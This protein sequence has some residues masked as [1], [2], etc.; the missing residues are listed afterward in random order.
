MICWALGTCLGLGLAA[1]Q[2]LPLGFLSGQELG[3][4]RPPERTAAVVDDRSAPVARRGVH[5]GALCLWEP[6]PG[7]SQSGASPGRP[8]PE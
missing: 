8:Q 7:S 4:E 1:V 3:L 6:A 2:I 5:G